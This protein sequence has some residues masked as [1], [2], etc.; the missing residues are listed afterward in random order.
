[1]KDQGFLSFLKAVVVGACLLA[2]G[3][4]AKKLYKY[5]RANRTSFAM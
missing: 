2:L 3:Y 4:F 1:M 5:Y